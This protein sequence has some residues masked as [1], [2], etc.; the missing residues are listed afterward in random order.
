MMIPNYLVRFAMLLSCLVLSTTTALADVKIKTRQTMS[1]ESYEGTVYIKGKRQRTETARN[2]VIDI[3][4]CD[5]RRNLQISPPTS[6]YFINNWAQD[7]DTTTPAQSSNAS[8]QQP[9]ATRKGGLVTMTV[10]TKDTGERKQMFGYTARHI[11]KTMVTE[12]SPDACTPFKNRMET[13]GW[14]IDA[15]FA[16]D[17][18][19]EQYKNWRPRNDKSGCQDRYDTKQIGT[20]KEGYPVLVKTTMFGDNGEVTYTFTQE[21]VE[22]SQ[23]TLD[24]ALFDAPAGFKEVKD[25]TALYAPTTAMTSMH[26]GTAGS[27][28]NATGNADSGTNANV[29]NMAKQSANASGEIGEKKPGVVRIGLATVKTGA[30]GEGMNATELSAA[31]GNTLTQFLKA[32][33]VEVIGI[34]ARLASQIDAEAKQKECDFVIYAT[35]SHKKGG[36]GG[37]MFGKMLG[38]V[39]STAVSHAGYGSGH[40]AGAIAGQVASTA[41]YSATSMSASVKSKD[42]LQLEVNMQ[43][44]GNA[45]PLVA[46]QLKAK[47]KSDGED[48]LSPMIEQAAQAIMDVAVKK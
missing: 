24:A 14:Y 17:C 42:E 37:G 13:D 33:N 45:T 5:L 43:T 39:A 12:S 35:A 18:Q 15:A 40:V 1:G 9:T 23:A 10:T 22:L 8:T 7:N 31:I 19:Y 2:P 26:T 20:A 27:D 47:A 32:P 4:Q 6:T 30:V 29:K 16:L 25:S 44:P 21:V 34:D 41:I 36:G 28:V 48:I 38:S 11:I 3:Q 46:K